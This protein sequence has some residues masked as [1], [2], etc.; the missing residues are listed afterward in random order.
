MGNIK[1]SIPTQTTFSLKGGY[2]GDHAGYGDIQLE[3]AHFDQKPLR[4]NYMVG[5]L[6][7]RAG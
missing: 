6:D 1:H 4:T 7:H 2:A 5:L 3:A